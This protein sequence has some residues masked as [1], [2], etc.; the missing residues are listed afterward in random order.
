MTRGAVEGSGR[1]WPEG[2]D[3]VL[4]PVAMYG[5]LVVSGYLILFGSRHSNRV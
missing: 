3:S 4:E 2:P 1:G 5:R